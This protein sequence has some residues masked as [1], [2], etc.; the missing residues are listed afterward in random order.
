[1][2]TFN[3]LREQIENKTVLFITTKNIDYI[4]NSQE[5]AFLE[6]N[7]G[8]VIKIFSSQKKYIYRLPEIYYKLCKLNMKNI[9][10]VFIGFS[11]QLILPFYRKWKDKVT[12]IDFFI[13]VYDT[14]VNDRQKFSP[15]GIAAR[16]CY[17]LDKKT[18]K[19]ADLIIVD[20]KEDGKY[21]SKEFIGT[22]KENI[23]ERMLVWYLKADEK[24][25][26]PR[27]M[28]KAAELKDKFVILYFGSIL[29]LQGIDIIL[30]AAELL[31]QDEKVHIQIIGP[32]PKKQDK[33]VQDNVEYIDWL[34]QAELA[35]YI[36]NADLCL[37]GHFNSKIAKASRTIAGKTYIYR[38][39]DK[40]VILGD[41]AANRE[42][43]EDAENVF[44]CEMGNV[45]ELRDKIL[46]AKRII[47][48]EATR[49]D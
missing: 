49:F 42:L 31:K 17:W 1:M 40:P 19:S 45:Q 44:F 2:E 8:R 36:A 9:D 22:D 48:D 4:R 26:Y 7:A 10:V 38:A 39:M 28:N 27:P 3:Q 46:E 11:P 13:S 41:N 16:L 25:Y 24:I 21:F 43:F 29:P 30:G 15:K 37:A 34:P 33:P 35:K 47:L 20:T 5:V 6:E 12:I 18:L 32:I 14:L 23:D